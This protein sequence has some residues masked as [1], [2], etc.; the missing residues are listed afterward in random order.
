M[1]SSRLVSLVGLLMMAAVPVWASSEGDGPVRPFTLEDALCRANTMIADHW[2]ELHRQYGV[3]YSNGLTPGQH[4]VSTQPAK[5]DAGLSM[6]VGTQV[7][8]V[9]RLNDGEAYRI[10][11][12]AIAADRVLTVD[13]D[14]FYPTIAQQIEHRDR[15]DALRNRFLDQLDVQLMRDHGMTYD[16]LSKQKIVPRNG[17]MCLSDRPK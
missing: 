2:Q 5:T 12:P 3:G 11:A 16:Q 17:I 8:I 7:V 14:A 13:S 4:L 15:M 6:P 1:S 9:E 10:S